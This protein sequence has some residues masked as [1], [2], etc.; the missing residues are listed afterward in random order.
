MQIPNAQ[1]QQITGNFAVTLQS[2]KSSCCCKGKYSN[3]W[4]RH[5]S[6]KIALLY[7]RSRRGRRTGSQIVVEVLLALV[8]FPVGA[9]A[10]L[11]LETA[12]EAV[13]ALALVA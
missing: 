2:K 11:E 7:R 5:I 4:R 12:L 13:G 8:L 10:V 9:I 3:N 1:L 6:S